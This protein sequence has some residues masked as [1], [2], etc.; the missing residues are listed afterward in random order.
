MIISDLNVL[1]VVEVAEV[2]GGIIGNRTFTQS[3]TATFISNSLKSALVTIN[4]PRAGGNAA[5]AGAK[6]DAFTPFTGTATLV[7]P[8]R[9]F[10]DAQTFALTDY[11][12]GSTSGSQSIAVINGI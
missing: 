3:D 12:G 7:F 10:S 5:S 9:S 2:V 1:E 6:A 8:T 4:D 11:L